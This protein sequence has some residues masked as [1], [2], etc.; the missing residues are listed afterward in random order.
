MHDNSSNFDWNSTDD[1]VPV[2][3]SEETVIR[4]DS[5]T[6]RPSM[7]MTT[8]PHPADSKGMMFS[9]VLGVLIAISAVALYLGIDVG[10]FS[11]MGDL[12]TPTDSVIIT[13]TEDGHFS[14]EIVEIRSGQSVT[15]ENK[16]VDPQVV[17]SK[18]GEDLFPVQV[19]FDQPYTFTV[20]NDARGTY[21][22]YS[23]T[24]PED[25][26]VTFTVKTND[27]PSAIEQASEP[28]P[29][30]FTSDTNV[31][32]LLPVTTQEVSVPEPTVITEHSG[33]TATISLGNVVQNQTQDIES[34]PLPINPYTVDKRPLTQDITNDTALHS[35]APLMA[36]VRPKVVSSTGPEGFLFLFVPALVGVMLVARK[37]A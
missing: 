21:V 34:Q 10:S 27:F 8:N 30:P 11:L 7:T 32:P 9:A 22:Y 28:I 37:Y 25:R 3:S 19:L 36:T 1:V 20:P 35:G 26:S 5:F 6:Q 2:R 12:T 4:D 17:K 24:L 18:T 23:E 29:I 16:N 13:I 15:L 14:P 31:A 33:D